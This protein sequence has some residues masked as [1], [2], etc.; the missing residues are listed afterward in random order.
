M[1]ILCN[2]LFLIYYIY[3]RIVSPSLCL[4]SDRRKVNFKAVTIVLDM[5]PTVFMSQ[6]KNH[7][8]IIINVL[9]SSVRHRPFP[10]VAS[11]IQLLSA[12]L[13]KS[14]PLL[15]CERPTLSLPR[16]RQLSHKKNI[17]P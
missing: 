16:L 14:P 1:A 13:R 3:I 6:A 5:Q 2:L 7:F 8:I 11:Y 4:P 12:I 9:Q 17:E 15:A 10:F